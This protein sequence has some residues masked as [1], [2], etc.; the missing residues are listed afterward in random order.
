MLHFETK[1]LMANIKAQSTLLEWLITT[2]NIYLKIG[3]P[4]LNQ[5]ARKIFAKE[6]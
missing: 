6:N 2:Q 4:P 3:K 1:Y 5:H